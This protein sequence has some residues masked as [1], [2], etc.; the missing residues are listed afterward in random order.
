LASGSTRKN[1][2]TVTD[3]NDDPLFQLLRA[4]SHSQITYR[5]ILKHL[6]GD[7]NAAI[8]LQQIVFRFVTMGRKPFYK[9]VAP[10][11]DELHSLYRP[12]DSW[13][14]ELGFSE[15][16][17][18]QALKKIATRVRKKDR[19]QILSDAVPEFGLDPDKRN[20][21]QTILLNR[22]HLVAY[23]READNV[24]R[25]ELNVQL[26]T[27]AILEW[28]KHT[29]REIPCSE[30]G[31]SG[32]GNG[33]FPATYNRNN[34]I[35]TSKS[36]PADAANADA[37]ESASRGLE[38]KTASTEQ[39]KTQESLS[40]P[41]AR[42]NKKKTSKRDKNISYASLSKLGKF[43]VTLSNKGANI[44]ESTQTKTLTARQAEALATEVGF[45]DT[46]DE[47]ITVS[48]DTLFETDPLMQKWL[49]QA[50]H[51]VLRGRQGASTPIAR[52]ILVDIVGV[53]R[54]DFNLMEFYKW[55]ETK[56]LLDDLDAVSAV[57]QPDEY[58]PQY[59]DD[60]P[61]PAFP[62]LMLDGAMFADEDEA[63]GSESK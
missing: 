15:D 46:N 39:S 16:E 59:I 53:R 33:D 63:E 34:H 62:S 10:S 14:E 28:D 8:L 48:P 18:H 44:P 27:N 7:V 54:K 25:F 56:R 26:L 41:R 11:K 5:P 31:K 1:G 42:A 23:W 49:K 50:V 21:H 37:A 13:V 57:S 22:Q 17:Y 43:L 52:D 35:D 40:T 6:V 58:V 45:Y 32:F 30:D 9:F 4:K 51:P 60:G 55:R 61:A 3:Y 12:G 29:E 36:D 24:L 20:K 19:S 47:Y 2:R 38:S